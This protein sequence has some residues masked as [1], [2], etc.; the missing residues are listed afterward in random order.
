MSFKHVVS[1]SP[2]RKTAF[3]AIFTVPGV[4]IFAL[5]LVM[6]ARCARA[7]VNGLLRPES[8]GADNN[9]TVEALQLFYVEAHRYAAGLV[10]K[11]QALCLI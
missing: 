9:F 4:D 8:K 10:S 1:I 11:R 7:Q 6:R 2:R 3:L 5:A